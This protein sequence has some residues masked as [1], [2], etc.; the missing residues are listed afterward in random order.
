M[1]LEQIEAIEFQLKYFESLGDSNPEET[2][3]RAHKQEG[4]W[5]NLLDT[6]SFDALSNYIKARSI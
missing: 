4:E 6:I 2:V 3:L 1:S 5:G